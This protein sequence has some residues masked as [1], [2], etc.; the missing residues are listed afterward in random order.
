MNVEPKG[1]RREQQ[2]EGKL[3]KIEWTL[4]V[5][6][7]KKRFRRVYRTSTKRE[8][9]RTKFIATQDEWNVLDSCKWNSIQ[10]KNI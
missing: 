3:T 6:V 1:M 9:C 10:L 2:M 8:K 7:S 5:Y 4:C